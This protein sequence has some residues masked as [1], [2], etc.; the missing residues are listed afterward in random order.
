MPPRVLFVGS[1]PTIHS[2]PL[3]VHS[4]RLAAFRVQP[5]SLGTGQG[6]RHAQHAQQVRLTLVPVLRVLPV[7]RARSA[8]IAP[9]PRL[10]SACNVDRERSQGTAQPHALLVLQVPSTPVMVKGCVFRVLPGH[11]IQAKEEHLWQH[12][13]LAHLGHSVP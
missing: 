8:Q 4:L 12:V 11:S 5:A 9:P 1:V 3:K 7:Q 2:A 6:S 13:S 10:G